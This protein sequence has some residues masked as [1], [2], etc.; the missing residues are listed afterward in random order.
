MFHLTILGID[1]GGDNGYLFGLA[2]VAGACSLFVLWS[3]REQ[4]RSLIRTI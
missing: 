1:V 3:S 2:L 4:V